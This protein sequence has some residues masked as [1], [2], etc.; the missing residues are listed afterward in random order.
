MTRIHG[1]RVYCRGELLFTSIERRSGLE[2]LGWVEG[3]ETQ[4]SFIPISENMAIVLYFI[5]RSL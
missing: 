2:N 1:L 4:H 3:S 5:T